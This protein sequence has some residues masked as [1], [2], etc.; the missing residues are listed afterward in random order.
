MRT[1]RGGSRVG[2]VL[3][4]LL[5][6]SII[7]GCGG[8]DSPRPNIVFIL[9]DDLGWVDTG[10]YGSTFYETPNIDRLASEGARFTQFYTA[11]PVCSPTRASIQTGKDPARLHLTNWIGGEQKGMLLQ[12]EYIRE[13]PLEELT[14]GEAFNAAGYAAGYI[15]KWHLGAAGFLPDSQGYDFIFAVNRAGQPG[16]YFYP[17]ENENWPITNV[18]DLEGDHEGDYLTDRLTDAAIGFIE[19]HRDDS[20]FLTLSH[21]AVH[22]PLQSKEP[23]TQKYTSKAESLPESDAPATLP[24]AGR[25][26]TRQRQDHPVYAGMIESMDESVGRVLD[27]LDELGLAKNTVVVFVSDNGGL[28]TLPRSTRMPTSNL[29]LRAGKGWLYD[30]GTRVPMIVRWPGAID[31]GRVIEEP[32]ITMDLYPTLLEI[33]GLPP[34]PDQHLDGTSLAPLLL[35]TGDAGHD[36]LHWHFPHYH[37]SGNVPSSAIRV[38][39]YKLIEWLE[40]GRLEL[41]DLS[42][43]PGESTDLSEQMPE[44]TAELKQ[45]LDGWRRSVDAGMPTPNP[46]WNPGK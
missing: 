30:G 44:K 16:S 37:G 20:F 25:A 2:S 18:P 24:E 8:F 38:G 40:D 6:A 36:D 34:R 43:D 12:A 11:S 26:M 22:T 39:D 7:S 42:N 15:G 23:L 46:D 5:A 32:A 21:Y 13:L 10:V 3:V 45:I 35:E 4:A 31:S 19:E 1:A 28:S 14:V 9:I 41:Y 33:A 27:K 17:Y 29:P